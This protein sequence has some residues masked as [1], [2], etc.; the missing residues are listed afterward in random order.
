MS[1]NDNSKND[2]FQEIPNDIDKH[3]IDITKPI[4]PS[5]L[6]GVNTIAKSQ[7]PCYEL[8]KSIAPKIIIS[9]WLQ[10][11]AEPDCSIKKTNVEQSQTEIN[12][13]S[14]NKINTDIHDWFETIE[15]VNVKNSHL[16]NVYRPINTNTICQ[17]TKKYDIKK[18][19]N[20]V[21]PKFVVSPWLQSS[22][23]PDRSFKDLCA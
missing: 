23:T 10:S 17:E 13:N 7:T 8:N 19:D 12:K 11:S 22:V 2:W 16:I 14:T 20:A 18:L 6:I 4:S 5:S 3:K 21:C 1:Q 9:P 15:S